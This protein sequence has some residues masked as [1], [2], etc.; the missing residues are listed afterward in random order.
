MLWRL[1]NKQFSAQKGAGNR[2]AMKKLVATGTVPGI[3]AF[4]GP[5]PV[6]WCALAPRD[7]YPAL[8]RSRVMKPVDDQPCWSVSCL[9]VRR[10]YRKKGVATFLLKAATEHATAQ[11]AQILE[12]Y[13]VEPREKDIPPAFAWT[14][15]P[16]AFE[17]AGFKEVARRSATRPIMRI[18][19]EAGIS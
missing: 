16:K 17:A 6:G 18:R 9:F 2:G 8:T 7:D 13:P 15:I 19:L 12:G 5:Q 10:D 11:G 14:G 3:L 1:T 4:D